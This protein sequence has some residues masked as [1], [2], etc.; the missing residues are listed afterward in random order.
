MKPTKEIS[1]LDVICTRLR[2]ELSTGGNLT[3]RQI[4]AW[5][6]LEKATLLRRALLDLYPED[7]KCL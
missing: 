7:A 1:A 3:K 2:G 4:T 6:A 5:F